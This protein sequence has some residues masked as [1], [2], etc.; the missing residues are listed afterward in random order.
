MTQP[1]PY[2]L[3]LL[4]AQ[5]HHLT[6][7]VGLLPVEARLWRAAETEWSL[8]ECLAHLRDIE[9]EVFLVRISKVD[10]EDQPVL[11]YFDELAYH[12]EHWDAAEPVEKLLTEFVAARAAEVTLLESADW[13]RTGQ[14][15]QR[16]RLDLE[17]LATYAVNHTWEHLSQIMRVRLNYLTHH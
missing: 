5:T 12:K 8:Q 4:R 6:H 16:G 11:K 10:K 9:R 2:L 1:N 14:H 17:W 7:E 15:E 13:S 3:R